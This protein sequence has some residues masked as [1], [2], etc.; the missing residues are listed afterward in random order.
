MASFRGASGIAALRFLCNAWAVRRCDVFHHNRL[1]IL[2]HNNK[3]RRKAALLQL[4]IG[5]VF[6]I[7]P[8]YLLAASVMIIVVF[9]STGLILREP[10]L[11]VASELTRWM[12]LGFFRYGP[13][14]NGFIGTPLILCGVTWTLKFEWL[15]YLSLLLTAFAARNKTS[16]VLLPVIALTLFFLSCLFFQRVNKPPKHCAC[17]L[18]FCIQMICAAISAKGFVLNVANWLSSCLLS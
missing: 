15:F 1:F 3:K 13:D 9:S 2:V 4:Y 10:G 6:R 11:K 12:A 7:G 5:R 8:L 18:S 16:Y 17:A 14:I